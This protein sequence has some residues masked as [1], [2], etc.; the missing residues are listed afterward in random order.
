MKLSKNDIISTN[1]FTLNG[2]FYIL[3]TISLSKN[4][5]FFLLFLLHFSNIYC[6]ENNSNENLSEINLNLKKSN[7]LLLSNLDS[8]LI[9]A[10]KA[11]KLIN[12][13]T[14]NKDKFDVYICLGNVNNAQSNY[15]IA[16][17]YYFEAKKLNDID[18]SK[19]KN[20]SIENSNVE[21]LIKIGISFFCQK[22][23]DQA[24]HYF[25]EALQNTLKLSNQNS[26]ETIIFKQRIF[27]NIAAL[28][29]QQKQFDKALEYYQN[30]L[31]I[32]DKIGDKKIE[33]TVNNNI[34]I[35]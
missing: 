14:S 21:I 12:K 33:S 32:N 27:I 30:S 23:F 4:N 5:L 26:K 8:A 11:N 7:Y 19:G 2:F 13:E 16:L 9:Y 35:C 17:K 1:L 24:L 31:K 28:K 3:K 29:I 6:Q 20:T 25:D 34:G 10:E 18:S 15:P 22:S